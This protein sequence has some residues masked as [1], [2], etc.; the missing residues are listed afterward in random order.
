MNKQ[1]Q[2]STKRQGPPA[3]FCPFLHPEVGKCRIHAPLLI[4]TISLLAPLLLLVRKE[5][6]RRTLRERVER[7]PSVLSRK[8]EERNTRRILRGAE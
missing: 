7:H 3:P 4:A 5:Q 1:V 6:S 8:C 2:G